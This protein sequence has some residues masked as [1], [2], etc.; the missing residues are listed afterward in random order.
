M[1][2]NLKKLNIKEIWE[3]Y[4]LLKDSIPNPLG[5]D[6]FDNVKHVFT[7]A[8]PLYIKKALHIMY[9]DDIHLTNMNEAIVLFSNGIIKSGFFEFHNYV[10]KI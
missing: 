4:R 6:A 7:K 3:L 10:S 2:S 5:K 8:N 1:N 9:G